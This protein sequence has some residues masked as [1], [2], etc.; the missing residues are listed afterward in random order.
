MEQPRTESSRAP[1]LALLRLAWRDLA[2]RPAAALVLVVGLAVGVAAVLALSVGIEGALDSM[3]QMYAD[4]SGAADLE[5]LPAG[6]PFEPLPAGTEAAV[7]ADPDVSAVMPLVSVYAARLE[8]ASRGGMPFLP[9]PDAALLVLGADDPC[10]AQPCRYEVQQRQGE[11]ALVGATWATQRG[12]KPGADLHLVDRRGKVI[13]WKVGGTLAREGLGGLGFGRVVLESAARVRADFG[14]PPDAVHELDLILRPGADADAVLARLSAL[15]GVLVARPADR[16]EDVEQRLANMRA[17]TDMLGLAGLFL[18]AYLIHGQFSARAAAQGRALALLRCVGAS[19]RQVVWIFLLQALMVGI[20]GAALGAVLG[21][22]LAHAVAAVMALAANADLRLEHVAL[23]PTLFAAG[24]GLATALLATLWPALRASGQPAWEGLRA[25]VHAAEP[26][27]R[28]TVLVALG[29]S[30]ASTLSFLVL[31]AGEVDRRVTFVR[32]LVLLAG[33]TAAL[34]GLVAPL[35]GPVSRLAAFL[36]GP[37]GAL[38]ASSLR[39]RPART[40]LSAGAVLVSVALVGGASTLATGVADEV[41]RWTGD[42]LIWDLYATR[43]GGFTDDDVTAVRAL[44]G[45]ARA[46]SVTIKPISVKAPGRERPMSLAA[47]A[48]DVDVWGREA[49]VEMAP[50]T[51]ITAEEAM[52]ALSRPDAAMVTSVV[53]VQLGVKP[54]DTLEVQGK[55]GPAKVRI[56]A[57]FVDYDQNG[58]S[59]LVGRSF[60]REILGSTGVDAIGVR[61]G[62]GFS[63]AAVQD[64]LTAMPGVVVES[65]DTLRGRVHE[66]ASSVLVSFDLLAWLSGGIGLLSV[67]AALAQSAFERRRD[68]AALAALGATRRQ[69]EAIVVVEGLLTAALG[70]LLGLPVGAAVGSTFAAATDT[71]GIHLNYLPPWRALGAAALASLLAALLASW[72]PAR[73]VAAVPAGEALRAE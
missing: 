45:V 3:R 15:P 11:G 47:V 22:P 17:G 23:A 37:A 18:A 4:A 19:R 48:V 60:A 10:P 42:A 59:L 25:R 8:D 49:E 41:D 54:G 64:A 66:L 55:D 72:V 50:G 40:G 26:P 67:G 28:W 21:V 33:V 7:R 58:Y 53:A 31:P 51:T 39:W 56:I 35:A 20:P 27:S 63:P 13:T 2:R 52:D 73:R 61:V 9:G 32:L 68:L 65:R 38:G 70:A 1:L 71:L 43:V 57:Q 16:G 5:V 6:D 69:R 14:L 29:V 24:L 34:P 30:A 12:V 36:L 46:A 44:P 62:P